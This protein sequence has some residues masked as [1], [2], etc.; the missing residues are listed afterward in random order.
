[1]MSPEEKVRRMNEER[2]RKQRQKQ[3]RFVDEY[4]IDFNGAQAAI[5]AGYSPDSAITRSVKLM[6]MKWI[7]EE[8]NART[9]L[10]RSNKIC[11]AKEVLELLT[12]VA[13][14][15]ETEECVVVEGV[16]AGFS[17]ANIINKVVVPK[18]RL[19]ALELLGKAHQ[20]FVDRV[21]IDVV[22]QII[23]DIGDE[24]EG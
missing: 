19:R 21:K 9:A 20:M 10:L 3:M 17:K 8:I 18:D 7:Q 15:E 13:R 6:K 23:D 14:G 16:G 12:K 22:P 1:M 5:R 24:D 2:L 11:D 4:M